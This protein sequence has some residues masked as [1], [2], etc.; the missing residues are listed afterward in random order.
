V[1]SSAD[2]LPAMSDIVAVAALRGAPAAEA[3]AIDES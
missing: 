2:E 3:V 1:L